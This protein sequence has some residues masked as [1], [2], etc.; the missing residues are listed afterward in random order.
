METILIKLVYLCFF[1]DEREERPQIFVPGYQ[2]TIKMA[3]RGVLYREPRD[4]QFVFLLLLH[5]NAPLRSQ[6]SSSM[7]VL[8]NSYNKFTVVMFSGKCTKMLW[9]A[10]QLS[11]H[12]FALIDVF[13]FLS[14]THKQE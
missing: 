8:A 12:D 1:C 10:C 6:P 3:T 13:V 9:R 5:F 14:S 4:P 2:A 11:I 7:T